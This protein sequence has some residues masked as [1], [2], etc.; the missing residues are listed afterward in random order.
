MTKLLPY[1]W[2]PKQLNM[3]H[4]LANPFDERSDKEKCEEVGIT[5]MTLWRWR[6]LAGWNDTVHAIALRCIGHKSPD[7]LKGLYR[8]A[9]TGD[10]QAVKLF[11]EVIGKYTEKRQLEVRAGRLEELSEEELDRIIERAKEADEV[12]NITPKETK[13]EKGRKDTLGRSDT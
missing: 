6:R 11:L 7:V 10:P 2:T 9:R 3:Q 8:R 1:S 13:D 5:Q 4:L 12:I